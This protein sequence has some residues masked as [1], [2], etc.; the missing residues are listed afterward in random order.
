MGWVPLVG[1]ALGAFGAGLL[2]TLDRLGAAPLL[3]ATAVLAALALLTRGMHLDGLADTADGLGARGDQDRVRAVMKSPEVGAFG[4]IALVL[5]LL[6]QAAALSTLVTQGRWFAAGLGIA[7]GRVAICLACRRGVPA[8]APDGL[9]AMVAASLPLV[10][11]LLWILAAAASG[12]LTTPGAAWLGPVAVVAGLLGSVALVHRVVR[13]AGGV[14]G[15]TLG[16]ACEIATTIT[17][18]GLSLAT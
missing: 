9:G 8:A 7:V 14:T 3:A 1:A 6:A 5:V 4:V 18:A 12:V 2:W 15:D 13:R 16:A 17:L 10:V 11:P